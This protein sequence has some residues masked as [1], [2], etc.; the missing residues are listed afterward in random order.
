MT[1]VAHDTSLQGSP[2]HTTSGL[3]LALVSA[4]SFGLSGALAR[5]LLDAGWSAGAVVLIRI[6]LGAVAVVPFGLASLHG[7][8]RLLRRSLPTV[9][10]YGLLAVAGAQYCFFS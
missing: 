4:V 3:G 9:V 8:W 2:R 6:A 1:A 5:P 7:R 10:L